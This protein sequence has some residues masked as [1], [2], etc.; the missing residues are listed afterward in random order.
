MSYVFSKALQQQK[1]PTE[2]KQRRKTL[3][4]SWESPSPNSESVVTPPVHTPP[5]VAPKPKQESTDQLLKSQSL[6]GASKSAAFR[7]AG[8]RS[9]SV[10]YDASSGPKMGGKNVL[11]NQINKLYLLH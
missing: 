10:D 9:Y 5:F 2:E 7:K 1:S 8:T 6:D 3:P 11:L 4:T